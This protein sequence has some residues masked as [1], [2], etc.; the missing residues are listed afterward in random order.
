VSAGRLYVV[1]TPIG[2]LAD[3]TLRAL[4]VLRSVDII[5]AED[6]RHTSRLLTRHEIAGPRLISYHARNATAREP[7][8]LRMLGDG[9]SVALVTDAGTPGVSDPG[10]D[11]VR[12]WSAAGGA[13]V[14]IPGASASIAAISATGIA[15]P[16]WSFEGFLPR[17]GRDR[18]DRLARLAGDD[19]GAVLFEAG[20]RVAATL[21]DLADACGGERPVAVCRELTKL[22]EEIRHGTLEVL[23]A[24]A[25]DG[26]IDERGEVV[27]VLGERRITAPEPELEDALAAARAGVERLVAAGTA[28]GDAARQV[29]ATSGIPRRRLYEAPREGIPGGRRRGGATAADLR[30]RR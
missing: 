13:V 29:A 26:D 7:E 1:A 27:L 15:G 30:D 25:A 2:N 6:T 20:N 19:R 3:I 8:L 14:P 22:H 4:E 21:R 10:A 23:A 17:S 16:H 5:A 12:A 24:A 18:R 11:L 28:R 9:S